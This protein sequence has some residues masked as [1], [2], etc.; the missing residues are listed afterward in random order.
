MNDQSANSEARLTRE[1][2]ARIELGHTEMSPLVARVFVTVFLAT[3]ALPIVVQTVRALARHARTEAPS[4]VSSASVSGQ[5]AF[6]RSRRMRTAADWLSLVPSASEI[7]AFE[8]RL[9]DTS[10]IARGLRPWVGW[11]LKGWL[12]GGDEQVYFGRDGWLFYRPSVDSVSGPGFLTASWQRHRQRVAKPSTAAPQP[13]PLDALLQF[14]RQLRERGITLI[15]LP[16]PGKESLYPEK[17]TASLAGGEVVRNSSF[18]TFKSQLSAAGV[19]VFDPAPVLAATKRQA[20]AYLRTDTHWSPVGMRRVASDLAAWIAEENLLPPPAGPPA[21]RVTE[22]IRNV[23]DITA[24]LALPRQQPFFPAE[25]ASIA[26]VLG[27]EGEPWQPDERADILLLGDSF[28]NIYSLAAMGWGDSAGFAEQLSAALGRP[29]DRLAINAG[30]AYASRQELVRELAAGRDRLAGKRVVI[31]EFAAR[32]LANGDWKLIQFPRPTLTKAP[33]HKPDEGVVIHG[34]VTA[35]GRLPRPGSVPYKDCLLS[36][37]LTEV[38]GLPPGDDQHETL[39]YVL[40]MKDN[41]WLPVSSLKPGREVE[42]RL[43]PWAEVESKYGT[44]NRAELDDLD[45]LFLPTYW[46]EEVTP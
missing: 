11:I 36:I 44:Y 1:T 20:P 9:E 35:V 23:G 13:D 32:E 3:A 28:S 21:T 14:D 10:L 25:S 30:G 40:G 45:L 8:N 33:P 29:V 5:S 15:V 4:A 31:Y 7:R 34:R 38:S 39:V 41:Q 17:L 12:H 6:V 16:V 27:T 43:R 22:T 18:A 24:M 37:H 26:R 2:M 42:C 19:L 46:A